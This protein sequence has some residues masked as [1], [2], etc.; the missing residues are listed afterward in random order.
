MSTVGPVVPRTLADDLRL[1]T[2]DE[3]AALFRNRPDLLNPVPTDMTGLV[4]RAATRL[5]VIR[6]L[7]RLDRFTLQVLDGLAHRSDPTDLASVAVLVPAPIEALTGALDTLRAHAFLWG[8]ADALHLVRTVRDALGPSPGGTGPPLALALTSAPPA[9]LQQLLADLGL[10]ATMDPPSAIARLRE[11]LGDPPSLRQVL[12]TAPPEAVE[13][14]ARVDTNGDGRVGRVDREV[15]RDTAS[16]PL[17]WLLAHGLLI[18]VDAETVVLPAEV[19]VARRGGALYPQP[20]VNPPT[21]TVVEVGATVANRAGAGEAMT[22]VRLVEELLES[23]T[24]DPPSVLRSGGGLGVRDLKRVEKLLDIDAGRAALT[25][26]VAHA[27]GLVCADDHGGGCW[28]PAPA[29]DQW[30]TRDTAA[31]WVALSQAWLAS[32]RVV[33]LVGARSETGGV[34]DRPLSPLG[35]D[36]DRAWAPGLR[37]S[38]LGELAMLRVGATTSVADVLARLAW[39]APRRT[40]ALH[41]MFVRA[42]LTEAAHLGITGRDALTSYARPL[43][44]NQP[45]ASSAALDRVLPVPLDHVLVQADLT[46]VA[47]GPLRRDLADEL[48]LISVAESTGAAT[49]YRFSEASVRRALDVGRTAAELHEFLTR[50]SR[51]PVPQALTYLIDDVARRH[52]RIRVGAAASYLRCDDEAV[53]A[54]LMVARG[55][56]RLGLSRL[57][58]TVVAS[59]AGRESLLAKLR[60]L[61]YAPTAE[62]A[63]GAVTLHRPVARRSTNRTAPRPVSAGPSVAPELAAAAVRALRAGDRAAAAGRRA[64]AEHRALSPGE[65]EATS[66]YRRTSLSTTRERLHL[67]A[68]GG[69]SVWMDYVADDGTATDRIVDPINI[70]GGVLRAYD[71]RI[72]KVRSFKLSRIR[73]VDQA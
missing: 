46:A 69:A 56:A 11:T 50:V 30:L 4:A 49:V 63:A 34:R 22:T 73:A 71:H 14:L 57:A 37:R 59:T 47:P 28:L 5:S 12:E 20:Q 42:S 23:W 24:D 44:E 51:T 36:L 25:V 40:G 62:S 55:T 2:D 48:R 41:E 70:D 39:R 64:G 13:L 29:Y 9:R 7:D 19:A 45:D 60:E 18:A 38:V 72:N 53:I 66:G 32:S 15:R 21:V 68:A 10:P 31:R 16:S 52:G 58:P 1:R 17:E 54:E 35:A 8:P 6:A 33:A 27:A 3:L 26:E 61:G 65:S 43:L 67:A